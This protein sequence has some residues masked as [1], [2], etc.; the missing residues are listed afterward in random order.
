M[1][2]IARLR[3]IATSLLIVLSLAASQAFASRQP[4]QV[5][6][7]VHQDVTESVDSIRYNYLSHWAKTMRDISGREVEFEFI[8]EANAITT[9]DYRNEDH[10]APMAQ[11]TTHY[12]QYDFTH[13]VQGDEFLQKGLLLTRHAINGTV[14]GAASDFGKIGI[15]SLVS[16][17]FPAHELGHMFGATHENARAG[18]CDTYM[19]P[20][21]NSFKA[22]CYGYSEANERVIGMR[23]DNRP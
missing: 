18:W 16:Y 20:R 10:A 22:Q 3:Y 8:T 6:L 7:F 5:R 17:S 19:V 2:P 12:L 11:L 13:P 23:L 9:M 21:R 15:A 14:G 4:L 1:K